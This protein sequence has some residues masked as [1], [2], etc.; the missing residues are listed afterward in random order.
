[1][2]FKQF[3]NKRAARRK[4]CVYPFKYSLL[5]N[6]SVIF[7]SKADDISVSG[8]AIGTKNTLNIG[9]LIKGEL[10]LPSL[11]SPIKIL[12]KIV[13]IKK[14][15]KDSYI[16]GVSF[17]KIEKSD[18][19]VIEK[20]TKEIDLDTL[21]IRAM[22]MGANSVHLVVGSVP[23][24]SL[25][26]SILHLDVLPLSQE[27]IQ[28]MIFSIISERQKEEFYKNYEL[29][30][31]YTVPQV[32]RRF[33]VNI[34]FDK[35]YLALAAKVINTEIKSIEEL[36]LPPILHELINRKSGMV[37]VSGPVDSGK[38][39]TLASM[40][41]EINTKRECVIVSIEDPVEY[42]YTSKNSLICQRDVGL[43]TM[44]FSNGIRS[45]LRQNANVVLIGEMRD[46]DSISQAITAAEEGQLVF[47]TLHSPNA[48]ECINRLID[49]FPASQQAQ[50]RFQLSTCLES[51]ICQRLLPRA[52]GKGR[53]VATEV[54]M[55]TPAVRNLIRNAH[56]EQVPSYLESGTE[57][58]MHTMDSSL[59]DLLSRKLITKETA[60]L[61]AANK[62]K[63]ELF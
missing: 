22:K 2:L 9:A 28:G 57:F 35:G 43:D 40:I 52:D 32:N 62:K 3:M 38:S 37:I 11:E 6:E 15:A 42:V 7:D 27:D 33:R 1:M 26:S 44:S 48:I 34:Y 51:I 45:A 56:L 23:A 46:L 53:V 25:D 10:S 31:A 4:E 13:R 54:L 36:G 60:Y 12:G 19:D 30:F 18:L 5:D 39:T 41:E 20:Y 49:V 17:E 55:F 61:F 50:I 59:M 21:L 47:S 58:G 24:C 29:D 63:F 8:F 14:G 16:Y